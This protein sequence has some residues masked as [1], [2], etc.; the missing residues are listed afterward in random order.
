MIFNPAR[1][2]SLIKRDFIINQ[3][4]LF[5]G[6][7]GIAALFSF[8]TYV[9]YK[10]HNLGDASFWL[11]WYITVLFAG[12]LLLTSIIFWEFKSPAGPPASS[13]ECCLA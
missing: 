2:A 6:L 7:I 5:Y 1:F 12:G 4:V 13:P 8:I 9:G 11:G 10:S 3:K